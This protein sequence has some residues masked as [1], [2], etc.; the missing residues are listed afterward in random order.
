M[1]KGE[2]KRSFIYRAL[3]AFSV[4]LFIFLAI[5]YLKPAG[6]LKIKMS[7]E[8]V[9]EE[10]RFG[11]NTIRISGRTPVETAVRLA[12][13]TYA[14]TFAGTRPN[15]VILVPEGDWHNAVLAA[16]LISHPINAPILYIRKDGIPQETLAEMRR[17]AP[18]GI[19]RDGRKK[20]FIV[21][22]VGENVLLELKRIGYKYRVFTAASA[23]G[24]AL[25]IDDYK[26]VMHAGH[27]DSVIIVAEDGPPAYGVLAAAWN[28]HRGD[29]TAFVSKNGVYRETIKILSK[30]PQDAFIYLIGPEDVIPQGVAAELSKYGHVQRIPGTDPFSTA[31]G[32]AAY[33]DMGRNFGWFAGKSTREFGWGITEAGHNFIFANADDWQNAL[34]ASILSHRG[35]HG[36][37]LFVSAKEIPSPVENYLQMVQPAFIA[38]QGQLYNHGWIIGNTDNISY[39]LQMRLDGLLGVKKS[40]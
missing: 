22:D 30:R 13:V 31:A 10:S 5:A 20:V 18:Q 19:S 8:S 9:Q 1:K 11:L 33:K 12:Q 29:I 4:A 26:S 39:T 2:W 3:I 15:A 27:R 17:L 7:T 25:V 23:A 16:E 34:P 35:K 36:L 37:F 28:A 38:V 14:G 21:G 6:Y 40:G 24:M 32:F